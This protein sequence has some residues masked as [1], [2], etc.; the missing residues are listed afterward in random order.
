MIEQFHNVLVLG[1]HPDDEMACSGTISRLVGAGAR[2]AVVTFSKCSDLVPKGLDKEWNT[3]LTILG[4]SEKDRILLDV[5]NRRFPEHRQ[6]V[7]DVL[8]RTRNDNWDLVLVPDPDDAHQD[9]S[10]VAKEAIRVF[11]TTTMFAYELPINAV[12]TQAPNAFV[13]L[14]RSNIQAKL[15]HVAAYRTQREKRY[16]NIDYVAAMALTRGTQAGV[17]AAEAFRVIRWIG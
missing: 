4:I 7:L 12:T 11:K 6:V 10:T 3:A 15:R 17:Y 8:D 5:A 13:A 1:A 9:H 16:M 14:D 2:V